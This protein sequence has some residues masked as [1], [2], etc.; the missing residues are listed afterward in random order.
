M[1]RGLDAP[2]RTKGD[3]VISEPG[4]AALR[5]AATLA[6]AVPTLRVRLRHDGRLLVDVA[7]QGAPVPVAGEASVAAPPG[8]PHAVTPCGFRAAVG[9]AWARH[10]A[11]ERLAFGNLPVGI[12]PSVEIGVPPCGATFPGDIHRVPLPGR[13]LY[14]FATTYPIDRCRARADHH[15]SDIEAPRGSW[16]VGLRHDEATEVTLAYA[17]L[18]AAHRAASEDRVLDL[19]EALLA[20]L[21]VRQLLDD[22]SPAKS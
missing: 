20:D 9:R 15:L 1:A 7:P 16:G 2:P 6:H 10:R 19:L 8:G 18:D 22:L 17:E 12:E 3:P 5:R 11:G 4:F 13:Y 14:V 21:A